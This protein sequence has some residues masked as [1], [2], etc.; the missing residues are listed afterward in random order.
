MHLLAG[1][2]LLNKINS[3]EGSIE[4]VLP[5]LK[6]FKTLC[7]KTTTTTMKKKEKNKKKK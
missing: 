6:N 2:Q 5:A 3:S 7:T 1:K 4:S